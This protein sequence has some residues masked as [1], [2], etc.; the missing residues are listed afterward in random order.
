MHR[1]AR[2]SPPD[3]S[4]T[5]CDSAPPPAR[6]FRPDCSICHSSPP[7]AP[8]APSGQRPS[9]T[10]PRSPAP[11]VVST[12]RRPKSPLRNS[13]RCLPAALPR[14]VPKTP[15]IQ[16]TH[17][18]YSSS[19]R[20]RSCWSRFITCSFHAI[21]FSSYASPPP[22]DI[23]S[24]LV[25]FSCSC[26]SGPSTSRSFSSANHHSS[27]P[28]PSIPASVASNS[29]TRVLVSRRSAPSIASS[30]NSFSAPTGV[31]CAMYAWNGD[32]CVR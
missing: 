25:K 32:C 4:H 3:S 21:D 24:L 17:C 12:R 16:P 23:T 27:Q 19:R 20:K 2:C 8:S 13:A 18:P 9:D 14:H 15:C 29:C 30:L 10:E 31:F 11:S 7:H 22:I 28:L 26:S 6:S 5:C 1:T